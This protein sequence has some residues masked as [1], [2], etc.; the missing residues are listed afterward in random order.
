M[1]GL[2]Q[3]CYLW[4]RLLGLKEDRKPLQSTCKDALLL[5]GCGTIRL[6][7]VG[8]YKLVV[9]VMLSSCV[10]VERWVGADNIG[11]GE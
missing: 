3:A 10:W 6:V 2:A 9:Y 8:G 5:V 1:G 11:I 4:L 7:G